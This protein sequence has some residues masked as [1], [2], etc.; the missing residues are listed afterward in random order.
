MILAHNNSMMNP[1]TFKDYYI[2][3]C[4]QNLIKMIKD[5]SIGLSQLLKIYDLNDIKLALNDI[6]INKHNDIYIE[7]QLPSSKIIRYLEYGGENVKP[8]HLFSN[9][10]KSIKNL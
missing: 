10:N 4:E 2:Y 3:M 7:D 6:K 9:M 5:K 1:N 8:T